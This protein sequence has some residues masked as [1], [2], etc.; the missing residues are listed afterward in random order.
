MQLGILSALLV[1]SFFTSHRSRIVII[2]T[3]IMLL[4]VVVAYMQLTPYMNA[5]SR[6]YDFLP[7]GAAVRER[8]NFNY[9]AVWY[10]VL[11]IFKVILALLITGRLL[12]DRYDWQEKLSPGSVTKTTRR[13]RRSH[14]AGG[15]SSSSGAD[16]QI[17]GQSSSTDSAERD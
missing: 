15:A 11:D 4:L 14:P 9:F 13:R 8:E 10:R 5:L 2:S 3:S 7:A 6:S 12:F 17:A 1:T 16:A